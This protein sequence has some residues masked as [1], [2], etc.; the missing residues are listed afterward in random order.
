M[1]QE[2]EKKVIKRQSANH[3]YNFD[4]RIGLRGNQLISSEFMI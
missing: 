4:S 1:F 2:Y 3:L